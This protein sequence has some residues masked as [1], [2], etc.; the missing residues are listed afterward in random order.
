[1]TALT[2]APNKFFEF[3]KD[4]VC[5]VNSLYVSHPVSAN[6]LL[7][8][9]VTGKRIKVISLVIHTDASTRGQIWFHPNTGGPLFMAFR[10]PTDT[11]DPFKLDPNMLGWFE[12]GTGEGLYDTVIDHPI[13]YTIQYIVYTP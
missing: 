3:A 4:G 5:S 9:G 11:E 7:V 2:I 6:N 8:A 10:V 13:Y 12:T 1:M